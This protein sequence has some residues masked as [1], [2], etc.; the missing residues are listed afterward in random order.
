MFKIQEWRMK[1]WHMGFKRMFNVLGIIGM[2]NNPQVQTHE[3]TISTKE[4]V[5]LRFT[6]REDRKGN[7]IFEDDIVQ[8]IVNEGKKEMIV[9]ANVSYNKEKCCFELWYVR[10]EEDG[11]TFKSTNIKNPRWK[12]CLVIGNV[13]QPPK[14]VAGRV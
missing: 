12:E 10:P 13:F 6:Y 1:C 5:M 14:N 11:K 7:S 8:T 2:P 4:V 9:S 3:S